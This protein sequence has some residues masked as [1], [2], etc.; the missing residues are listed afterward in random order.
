MLYTEICGT[1]HGETGKGGLHGGAP[2]SAN[3]TAQS[4][5]D[6]VAKGRNQMPPFGSLYS[7]QQLQDLAAYV[8]QL[9]PK[10]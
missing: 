10:E 3:L 1:C 9:K 7:P 8:L 4:I 2:F 6:V 5:I